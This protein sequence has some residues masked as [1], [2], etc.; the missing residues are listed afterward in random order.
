MT[1]QMQM[2]EQSA[3]PVS[4]LQSS[5]GSSM[6]LPL[7]EHGIPAIP[8]QNGGSSALHFPLCRMLTPAAAAVHALPYVCPSQPHTGAYSFVQKLGRGAHMPYAVL[9]GQP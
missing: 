3:P 4:G 7:P 9:F 2:P 5:D 1:G 8:P 6:H